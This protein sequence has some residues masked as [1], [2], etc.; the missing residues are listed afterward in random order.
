MGMAQLE[1]G[2][3]EPTVWRGGGSWASSP[4][5][6]VGHAPEV[7]EEYEEEP[8]Y[9]SLGLNFGDH[10]AAHSISYE[11]ANEEYDERPVYRSVSLAN[12]GPPA[13]AAAPPLPPLL[14]RQNAT[15]NL[16]P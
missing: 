1:V 15:R 5:A 14:R 10:A 11:I 13:A 3:A 12:T 7:Y 2:D 16:L 9:R 4:P 8:V 6:P